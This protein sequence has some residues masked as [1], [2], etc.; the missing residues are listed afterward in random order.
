MDNSPADRCSSDSP[1][2]KISDVPYLWVKF[3][4]RFGKA[5]KREGRTETNHAGHRGEKSV[6]RGEPIAGNRKAIDAF[7][8]VGEEIR[9]HCALTRSGGNV[10]HAPRIN[11]QRKNVNP[12]S[13]EMDILNQ[14]LQ[15]QI[16]RIY[17][18]KTDPLKPNP[19][20]LPLIYCYLLVIQNPRQNV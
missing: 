16:T 6:S 15:P 14:R 17:T 2:T 7:C 19:K 11:S 18:D 20:S 12:I 10:D 5:K 13:S 1:P 9:A 8:R 3:R 4:A